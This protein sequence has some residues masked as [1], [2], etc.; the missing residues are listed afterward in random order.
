MKKKIAIFGST[1]SIG[2]NLINLIKKN[3]K[4]YDVILLTANKSSDL[5]L[6]QASILKA[7]NIIITD[8]NEF[9]KV[10]S[11]KFDFNIYPNFKNL[12]KIFKKKID[13]LMSS[14]TGLEGLE[15]TL[16]SIKHTKKIAIA[17]K[18]SLICG[19]DLINK[20]LIKN[21]TI[22]VPV[23][24][25]HFSIWSCINKN[26]K[27]DINNIYIT[28]SGGPFFDLPLSKF[29][30]IQVKDAIKHPNWNMGSKISID[31]ATMMNKVFEVIEAKNIFDLSMKQIK[32]LINRD[33]YL[34]AIVNFKSGFSK[35]IIHETDMR[36]P[37][38]N[39]LNEKNKK[40]P[41][42]SNLDLNKL[43]KLN[44]HHPDNK[45]FPML[46]VL[47]ILPDKFT[48]FNTVIVSLNDI[49]VDLFLNKFIQYVDIS[50][51]FFKTL[52]TKKF[53]KYKSIKPVTITDIIKL[54]TYV[55][56]EINTNYRLLNNDKRI[57]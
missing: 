18:E 41:N 35:M 10:S 22:F 9:K 52:N 50:K 29:K 47:K 34:H 2:K 20:E 3:K 37:I 49:L 15:P 54:K 26:T 5:L 57:H 13:Y 4:N 12:N 17:N 7:K 33:S 11:K 55:Q 48:L 56:K 38:F 46:K 40:I 51:I 28:A 44:L 19:W 25:E 39:T 24:S 14:I 36:I 42:L 23:D 1:G 45:K 43:N 8:V 21:K 27:S 53:D 16:M 6:K 32:I 30:S 31:S